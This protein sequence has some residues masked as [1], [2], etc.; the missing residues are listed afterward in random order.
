MVSK[1]FQTNHP[2]QVAVFGS[3]VLDEVVDSHLGT[4]FYLPPHLQK[5]IVDSLKINML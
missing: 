1:K 4:L 5:G 3:S 2:K